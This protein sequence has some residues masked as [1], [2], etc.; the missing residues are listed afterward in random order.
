M[1]REVE[2]AITTFCQAKCPSCVRTMLVKRN[3]LKPYHI[4]AD[5]YKTVANNLTGVNLVSLC[6][7]A[8]DP[9]MHPEID[10]IIDCFL[11][12]KLITKY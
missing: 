3:K 9:L 8:G 6:G 11:E 5:V 2:F 1:Y 12:K 4:S 10:D 7:E